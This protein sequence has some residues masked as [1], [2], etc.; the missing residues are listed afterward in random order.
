[1]TRVSENAEWTL[2][3]PDEVRTHELY[4]K[5]EFEKIYLQYEEKVEL[6]RIRNFKKLT[7]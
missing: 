5:K 1:M 3:S 6:G 2:F 7:P 4:G